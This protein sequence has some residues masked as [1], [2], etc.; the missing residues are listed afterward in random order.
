MIKISGKGMVELDGEAH[1]LIV[2][3]AC[4]LTMMCDELGRANVMSQLLAAYYSMLAEERY[5]GFK[6]ALEMYKDDTKEALELIQYYLD[7]PGETI[8]EKLENKRKEE[9]NDNE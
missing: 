9:E 3:L 2:E 8:E 6:Q 7:A 5:Y 1:D 4:G